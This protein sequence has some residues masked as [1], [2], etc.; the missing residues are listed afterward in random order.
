MTVQQGRFFEAP[1]WR[2]I[3][4]NLCSVVQTFLDPLALNRQVVYTLNQ[5]AVA[6]M[7]V[8]SD[9]PEINIEAL[10]GDPFVSMSNRLVFGFR[11]DGAVGGSTP[12]PPWSV[13][14][15]GILMQP[16]DE[17]SPA[18]D[19]PTTHLTAF[20]PWTYLNS[21]PVLTAAGVLPGSSGLTFTAKE[22]QDIV[23]AL[24][25]NATIGGPSG[26][27]TC[28]GGPGSSGP[29]N[30]FLDFGQT[31]FYGGNI[32]TIHITPTITI[33][34]RQ[35]MMVGDALTQLVQTGAC[36]V[37]LIPIWDPGNRP[38]ICCE[39]NVFKLAGSQH[40]EAV[41][42]W[43]K[44]GRSL[45]GLNRLEDGEKIANHPQFYAGQGGKPVTVPTS[46]AGAASLA[47]YGSYWAQDFFPGL[48]AVPTVVEVL[49]AS[50][51]QLQNRGLQT[52]T[53]DPAP[54]F[55]PLLFDEYFLGDQVPV[56]ASRRFR[57]PI[58]PT[59]SSTGES[60]V[61]FHRIYQI[62]V[63]IPDDAPEQVT[64]LLMASPFVQ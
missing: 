56:Y 57:K 63:A 35:G 13:R 24:L 41:F 2:F 53:M 43:D 23:K 42:S 44:P 4:T 30:L 1:P 21:R 3:T 32:D 64:G 39:V 33:N 38:G 50:R 60:W 9:D 47:K 12:V 6:T 61:D 37:L 17:N 46:S 45:V 40:P 5:A 58:F 31:A 26:G 7:S 54:E 25:L 55:A 22:P 19:S 8:P 10:D 59:L 11:R 28:A 29:D 49:A 20:D 48:D 34:F 36:D 15:A 18:S 62:P 16:N 52:I 51:L 27:P 14:F